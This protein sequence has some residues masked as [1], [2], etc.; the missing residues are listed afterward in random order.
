MCTSFCNFWFTFRRKGLQ[1]LEHCDQSA[2]HQQQTMRMIFSPS[3]GILQRLW[4]C[5]LL[6]DSQLITKFLEF[7]VRISEKGDYKLW[8][9]VR[10]VWYVC[11]RLTANWSR[12]P[13]SFGSDSEKGIINNPLKHFVIS[14]NCLLLLI[15]SQLIR[16]TGLFLWHGGISGG[17]ESSSGS[18]SIECGA[19]HSSELKLKWN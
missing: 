10:L 5:L 8:S 7:F 14:L 13:T 4:L 18:A 9:I 3:E 2:M 17:V 11:C 19:A 16:K 6:S 12:S 1:A 15:D